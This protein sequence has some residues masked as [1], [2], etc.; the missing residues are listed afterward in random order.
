MMSLI[1]LSFSAKIL[2]M[3]CFSLLLIPVMVYAENY[4]V[5]VDNKTITIMLKPNYTITVKPNYTLNFKPNYT[6]TQSSC[7]CSS[8]NNQST[9]SDW[10]QGDLINASATI[11]GFT[12]FSSLL[13]IKFQNPS[14]IEE[15]IIL[16]RQIFVSIGLIITIHVLSIS[17]ILLS[18]HIENIIF[19]AYLAGTLLSFVIIFSLMLRLT[20]LENEYQQ[21]VSSGE[22]IL[23]SISPHP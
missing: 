22:N 18:G 21:A 4:T 16:L 6:I 12:G 10:S 23:E 11:I 1:T 2:G 3:V 17:T 7:N 15:K 5:K 19:V 14:R 9:T 13:V 8:N 20:A